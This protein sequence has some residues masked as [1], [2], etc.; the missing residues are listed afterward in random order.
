MFGQP[1]GQQAGITDT[2]Q[3]GA[4]AFSSFW[5]SGERA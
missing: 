4:G 1:A 3:R 2:T 5:R